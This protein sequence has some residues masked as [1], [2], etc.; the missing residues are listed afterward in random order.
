[1]LVTV[2]ICTFNRAELLRRTLESLLALELPADVNWEV[3]VV[4]NNSTDHTDAVVEEYRNRLPVRREF[5]PQP[6]KSNALNRAISAA[7]GE[8]IL[9]TDDDVVVDPN[10]LAAYV[11]AFRRRPEAALFGGPVIPKLEP[12]VPPWVAESLSALAGPYAARDF[13]DDEQPLSVAEDRVPYGA[14]F[15]IRAREQRAVKYDPGLGPSPSQS[16]CGEE[17]DVI[18]RVLGSGA[19]GYW[20]PQAVANHCIGRERQTVS[21]IVKYSMNVGETY[22]LI[23][24]SAEATG[25][26]WFGVPQR[27]W[28]RLLKKWVQYQ[29]HRRIS[30]A[31]IWVAHLQAYARTK[32]MLRYWRSRRI[33]T[34]SDE[35]R[36]RRRRLA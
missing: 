3:V 30:P 18:I 13:S 34:R 6:G 35:L 29:V 11:G 36:L 15:A 4:N 27:V 7:N 8:Y 19:T 1:M 10:W 16:R 14:N 33:E 28:P 23:S 32:G 2:G 26:F 17:A 20:I 24:A 12:P 5:E 25:R 22:A 9:W 21:Y 31:P